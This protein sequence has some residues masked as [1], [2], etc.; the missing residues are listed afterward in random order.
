MISRTVVQLVVDY[1]WSQALFEDFVNNR[2]SNRRSTNLFPEEIL[3]NLTRTNRAWA[4]AAR[5]VLRKR[6]VIPNGYRGLR[7]T[8]S[9]LKHDNSNDGGIESYPWVREI[10]MVEARNFQKRRKRISALVPLLIRLFRACP[11][12]KKMLLF[13]CSH[14][15]GHIFDPV[16]LQLAN[17]RQLKMLWLHHFSMDLGITTP[18]LTT[19]C[20]VLPEL[21][22]LQKLVL[23]GW[24]SP[25]LKSS[26]EAHTDDALRLSPPEKLKE[27]SLARLEDYWEGFHDSHTI[28]W[29][30][31]PTPTYMPSALEFC[32]DDVMKSDDGALLGLDDTWLTYARNLLPLVKALQIYDFDVIEH[33]LALSEILQLCTSLE[34]L[35][36]ILV[37]PT[38]FCSFSPDALSTPVSYKQPLPTCVGPKRGVRV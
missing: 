11:N 8:F 30:L 14:C 4:S 32:I 19:L 23:S 36:L 21:R 33:Y 2:A 31:N 13:F 16:I 35:S 28:F 34:K 25:T 37:P 12:V 22:N 24:R 38:D 17:L 18:N 29:L 27:V 7:R 9:L 10:F 20:A 15:E 3:L 6:I 26:H 5:L 1:V